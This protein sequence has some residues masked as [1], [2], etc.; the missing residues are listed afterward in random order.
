MTIVIES[1]FGVHGR[2]RAI[3]IIVGITQWTSRRRNNE[4]RRSNGRARRTAI[5][6]A[7]SSLRGE[8]RAHGRPYYRHGRHRA[9]ELRKYDNNILGPMTQVGRG[10]RIVQVAT[11]R[12]AARRKGRTK[13]FALV[14]AARRRGTNSRSIKYFRYP[15]RNTRRNNRT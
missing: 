7:L 11:E 15:A 6:L 2:R 13:R 9:Y 14:Y 3:I 4:S 1:T 10:Y 12:A 8:D 5:E